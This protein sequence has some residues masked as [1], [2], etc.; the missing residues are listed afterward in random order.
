MPLLSTSGSYTKY[1]GTAAS[2]LTEDTGRVSKRHLDRISD[3]IEYIRADYERANKLKKGDATWH[4]ETPQ[5]GSA[6]TVGQW[7][8][9][10]W[11]GNPWEN[12]TGTNTGIQ[13]PFS[14]MRILFNDFNELRYFFNQGG[15]I[16]WEGGDSNGS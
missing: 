8:S 6:T 1:D 10:E 9:D 15:Q 4:S 5:S 2:A 14:E 11:G 16:I 7:G 13:R 12:P 3:E